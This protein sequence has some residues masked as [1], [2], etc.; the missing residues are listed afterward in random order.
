MDS[1]QRQQLKKYVDLVLGRWQ[2]IVGCLLLGVGTGLVFYL[3]IPKSFQST[4]VLS[5]EQQQINPTKMDP[6]QG[7]NRLQEAVATLQEMVTSRNSLEK[8]I[9]QFD[10]YPEQRKKLPIEDVIEIMRRN[11]SIVPATKGD[12]FSVSFQGPSPDKVMK[13]TNA[14]AALFIEE[15]LKY[16]EER[17][18]ETSKYTQDELDMAKKVLDAKEQVMRD[19][20]LKYYNEMPEQR[21]GNLE[22]LNSLNEQSQKLQ[23]SIHNLERTKIMAQEQI[24]MMQRLAATRSS[25]EQAMSAGTGP[26]AG[27]PVSDA[28]R[29][30]Q[31]RRYYDTLLIKYTDKHP[32]VRRTK[33]L[34]EQLQARVGTGQ[35]SGRPPAGAGGAG[36]AQLADS[37]EMGRLQIQIGE[38]DASLR[39]MRTQLAALPAEIGKYQAWIEATPVREAEWSAL[40]RD[41]NELRRHY[42]EL[43][44]R[45]LQ[46]QSTETLERKQKGSKFKIVDPARLPDKPFKPNFLKIFLAAVALGLGLGLGVTLALDFVDTS[47]K[48]PLELEE[49]L[50]VPVACA[51]AYIE[52]SDEIGRKRKRFLFSVVLLSFAALALVTAILV[53]WLKGRIII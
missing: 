24:N 16:R 15:N 35:E 21:A 2:L 37:M 10:L 41:Y 19:Y 39:Q 12:V 26:A 22:R 20:K 34:I 30:E 42:D 40:T 48:D 3:T 32:E 38:Y 25:L 51:V 52:N 36:S 18:T 5:Y 8:V 47:F 13:V 33:Q 17:A 1:K 23:E 4:S 6:E 50:G 31:L 9:T 46:A 27:A 11:I 43:V 14:L 49:Y 53:L 7:R 29:L 28:D 45:N 44:A